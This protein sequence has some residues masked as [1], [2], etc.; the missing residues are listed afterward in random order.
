MPAIGAIGNTSSCSGAANGAGTCV[1]KFGSGCGSGCN[2]GP[3]NNGAC[4][5]IQLSAL[6]S[7]ANPN[8]SFYPKN[9]YTIQLCPEIPAS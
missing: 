4:N 1:S 7:P 9:A 6:P 8:T 2:S 3:L 5:G